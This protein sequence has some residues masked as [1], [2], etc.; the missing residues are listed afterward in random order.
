MYT[1]KFHNTEESS[2]KMGEYVSKKEYMVVND[3]GELQKVNGYVVQYVVKETT[4]TL[5]DARKTVLNTSE[6]IA[7]FT[8]DNVRYM[9]DSYIERFEIKNGVSK[10]ADAFET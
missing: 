4:V 6:K 2:G 7:T 3:K 8:K 1:L 9:C 10:D 5:N